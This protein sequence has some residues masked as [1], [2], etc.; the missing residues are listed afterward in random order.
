MSLRTKAAM[1]FLLIASLACAPSDPSDHSVVFIGSEAFDR[2]MANNDKISIIDVRPREEYLSGHIPGAQNI[3]RT[4]LESK[5][6]PY[7]G[8]PVEGSAMAELL[9]EKGVAHDHT[10]LLYDNRSG[11]EAARVYLLLE[12]Y[13]HNK[14]FIL[15]GGLPAWSG[16]LS[17]AIPSLSPT[18]FYFSGVPRP[19]LNVS[20]DRFEELRKL[21]GVVIIDTRSADEYN[22]NE[23]K[24]GSTFAGH[25][26]NAVN[27]CYSNNLA[28]SDGEL[29]KLKSVE[30]LNSI[31]SAV[32]SPDD[33]VLLYCHSGVRSSFTYL[34]LTKMLGYKYVYNYDGSWSEWSYMNQARDSAM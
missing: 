21:P 9:G 18:N 31:Y 14:S 2:M 33:T 10:I 23:L 29:V 30:D 24:A 27:I 25:V 12:Q 16:E 26:P 6:Y 3:W 20:Y 17:N 4:D 13:G 32:A 8:M 34:V 11:V 5:N 28:H 19:D 1:L 7:S 22:A 15:E